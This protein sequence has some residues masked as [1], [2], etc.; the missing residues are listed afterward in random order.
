[1]S[2]PQNV[3][4]TNPF[5]LSGQVALITGGNSGVGLGMAEGLAQAGAALA[6]WGTNAD[7]NARA[8][9]LL[10]E[11]GPAA[12]AFLCDV[13]DEAQVEAAFAATIERY[14]RI[15]SCFANA[16]VGGGAE[17]FLDMSLEEWRRVT[18][19]NL[20]GVFLTLRGAARHMVARGGGGSL[21][22]TSCL[23]AIQGQPRGQHYAA[24]KG[25]VISMMRACAIEFARYGISANAILPGWVE[26][27]ASE[28]GFAWDAMRD[29]TTPR[30]PLRRWGVPGDFA[31]IAVYLASSHT[32]F[33]TGEVHVIDGGYSI[34]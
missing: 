29:A 6:I 10:R 22:V 23:A 20:D 5:D 9:E 28:T 33:H 32:R 13:G 24:T 31:P 11:R 18:R 27:P 14:G 4:V 2:I 21:V 19:I 8:V 30:M 1:M 17:S 16:G 26:A 25:G 15:D 3:P 34:F 7:S 12:E